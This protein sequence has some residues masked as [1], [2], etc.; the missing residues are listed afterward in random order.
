ETGTGAE[1]ATAEKRF[2]YDS[3][4][5]LTSASSPKGN[6][7]Y[8]YDDRGQLLKSTGPSGDATYAYNPD[9]QLTTRTDAAGTAA[10]TYV[11]R[12][13][14]SAKDPLTGTTQSYGYDASGTLDRIGYGPGQSRSLSYDNL[15]RLDTDTVKNSAGQPLSSIDYGYDDADR[16]TSKT[17]TGGAKP[18]AQTYGYDRAGRLT[19]WT[20]E[21]TTTDYRWDDSGN[22]TKNGTKTAT[23][24]ERNRLLSDG[25]YS[26]DHTPRGTL[27][28]RTSS[29]LTENYTFDAFDRLTQAGES[30]TAYTYDSLDRIASR[31]TADFSYAGLAP[32][33]VKDQSATYGRGAAHELLAV[34]EGTGPARLTLDDKRGDITGS[35][36]AT[37]GA[38]TTLDESA[39]YDPFGQRLG[40][41][42][43]SGNAGYQGDYTDPATGQTSMHARWYDPG[44]GTFDSRD[45]AQYAAGASILA[46][47][48]TYGAGAPTNFTDPDGNWPCFG[49]CKKIGGAIKKVGSAIK[50]VGGFIV[51]TASF[52]SRASLYFVRNPFS[53]MRMLYS[54]V[55]S[56]LKWLYERSGLKRVVDVAR[57]AIRYAAERTGIG[58]WAKDR[59]EEAKRAARILK[60]QI[61]R[62]ARQVAAYVAKHNP[63]PAIIAA[64]KPLMAV[65]KA[66]IAAVPHIPALVVSASRDVIADVARS[67]NAIREAAVQKFGSVVESV[68]EAVDWGAV[69]E[70]VKDAGGVIAEITG[71]NDLKKCVTKGDL[72]ACAW[73]AATLV[74][75]AAG[76]VGAVAVRGLRAGKT[77]SQLARRTDGAANAGK[78]ERTRDTAER[79]ESA[80][81][82]AE[83]AAAVTGNSFLPGTKVLMADGSR[84]PIEK[85][86]EG[87]TVLATDPTTGKTSRQKVTATIKGSGA[88]DLV[89]V[90]VDRDGPGGAAPETLTA[91]VGHPFWVGSLGRWLKAGELKPGQWLRTGAGTRVQ[92]EAVRGWTQRAAVYNLTVDRAHTY[93][94]LAGATPVLVHNCG[95]ADDDLLDFADRALNVRAG[96]R[97]NVATKITSADGQHVRFAYAMDSRT[98]T[99]PPRTARAVADSGHHGGCGEVGCAIKFEEAKI[100]LDGATYQSVVI[101]GGGRGKVFPMEAHGELLDP[102]PAC[103]RFLP[104]IGGRG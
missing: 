15:G 93:Y 74:G 55:G 29:G 75:A 69:W 101:G 34:A 17:T 61:T 60:A 36:S 2:G 97:P 104:L 25:D 72:E 52:I 41:A 3:A 99:M 14:T 19:S 92:V 20:A 48:Y 88:K 8:E 5:R 38:A 57:G 54:A 64:T 94:A 10:F 67:A 12:R 87:D 47:R 56:G 13:L 66:V 70:G 78:L 6:N 49:L 103:R 76:G 37:D 30:N 7:A 9:G 26:Y 100:P 27:A 95:E 58:R 22:R 1:S 83:T 68:S 82:C 53:A 24:D 11:Q 63:I 84:K 77:V 90:T 23:Y 45:A 46:N 18:G 80:V 65:A 86:R 79:V 33:P 96:S 59:L 73:S 89:E 50:K 35:L 42:D 40:T 71:F 51:K 43:V 39:A 31:G 32:D 28:T 4:G 85:V 44:T 98:G 16:L 21:G 81:G 102:C 91:T 62:K